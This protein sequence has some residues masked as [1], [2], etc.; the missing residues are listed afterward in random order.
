VRV[1]S[2]PVSQPVLECLQVPSRPLRLETLVDL[3]DQPDRKV[4]EVRCCLDYPGC[5][6]S[7]YR[8]AHRHFQMD[9]VHQVIQKDQ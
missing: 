2:L 5:L 6:V 9:R 8:R 3:E 1:R 7:L 4:L